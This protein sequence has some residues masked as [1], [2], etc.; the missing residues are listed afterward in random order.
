MQTTSVPIVIGA[1]TVAFT[2]IKSYNGTIRALLHRASSKI[3][4]ICK[5]RQCNISHNFS[6]NQNIRIR[7][8]FITY[9]Q[10]KSLLFF[11]KECLYLG[12]Y[13]CNIY[14]YRVWVDIIVYLGIKMST[15]LDII[16]TMPTD[17]NRRMY[18]YF[19]QGNLFQLKQSLLQSR[20]N[21]LQQSVC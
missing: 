19:N 11:Y 10:D 17:R 15:G 12:T 7:L 21:P 5:L 14:I 2:N 18:S 6:S 4:I 13:S 20:Q 16:E 9:I 1:L 3:Y 8:K